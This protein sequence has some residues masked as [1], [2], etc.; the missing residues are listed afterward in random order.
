MFYTFFTNIEL[1]PSQSLEKSV[2]LRKTLTEYKAKYPQKS[3]MMLVVFNNIT[4]M[5]SVCYLQR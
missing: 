4:Y 5:I 2:E 1:I 3:S